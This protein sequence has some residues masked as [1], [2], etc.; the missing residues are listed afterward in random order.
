VGEVKSLSWTEQS[1]VHVREL[2]AMGATKVCVRC[3]G[4]VEAEFARAVDAP[5]D[6]AELEQLREENHRLANEL[7][8]QREAR[9]VERGDY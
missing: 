4:D 2:R 1:M 9:R 7:E 3:G 5:A 8:M 6:S